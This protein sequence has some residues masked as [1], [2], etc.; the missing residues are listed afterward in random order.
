MPWTYHYKREDSAN[1]RCTQANERNRTRTANLHLKRIC[2]GNYVPYFPV[3]D[4][5]APLP[6]SPADGG[7][8]FEVV[9]D[10][11]EHDLAD[12][13]PDETAGWHVRNDPFSS[14]RAG[15]E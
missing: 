15:F 8:Q 9:F 13:T 12:P 14:Y 4:A 1:I 3:L 11:G 10:Y 5:N 7:W 6:A 2:Y